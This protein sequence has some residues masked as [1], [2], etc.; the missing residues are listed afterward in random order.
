MNK[1]NL[2]Y[3]LM[4][5]PGVLLLFIFSVVPMVGIVMAFQNYNPVAPWFGL[6]SPFVGLRNFHTIF[7]RHPDSVQ[8][9][10][11]TIVIAIWKIV[12]SIIVPVVFALL[13]NECLSIWFKRTVQTVVYLPHFLSWV[14][15]AAMFSNIFSMAGIVNTLLLNLRII[16]EPIM[17]MASNIWFRPILIFTD[18]WKNFGFGAIVF[19]A[20]ITAID[21]NQYE[22]A[23]IDG[24]S[25]WQKMFYITIPGILPTIILM[26]T[27]ALGNILH[28]GFDQV[29][30]MYNPAVY[31]TGDIIDTFVFR[32][33]LQQLR[34]HHATAVGLAR[35]VISMVLIVVAWKLADKFAGY[36]IF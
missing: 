32:I 7:I 35:S 20:A 1:K 33:G 26:S 27:L 4:M 9:V 10:I 24:A 23:S 21:V 19:I 28:A 6:A 30:N 34:F 25:R 2:P 3:H 18:V 31:A 16:D 29:F 12:M 15:A 11:N 13:L 5:L 22:A 17:F 36:R 14:I 8:V